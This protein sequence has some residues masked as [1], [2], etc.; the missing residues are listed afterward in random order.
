MIA[1]TLLESTASTND[2]AKQ[3]L[4]DGASTG[5]L[6]VA[7]VQ[8]AGRGRQ[9][10]VWEAA[11]GD[12]LMGSLVVR[13]AVSPRRMSLL[14]LAAGL[15]V[16]E[17]CVQY[18]PHA[19]LKWPN[20]VRVG[21]RKLAGILC[22][23]VVRGDQVLGAVIGVGCNVRAKGLPPALRE[24]AT[25]LE[26]HATSLPNLEDLAQ[27]LFARVLRIADDVLAR[28]LGP[29]VQRLNAVHALG[30]KEVRSATGAHGTVVE[31]DDEG[32]LV[33]RTEQG[34]ERWSSGEVHLVRS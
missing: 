25:S 27:D 23:T 34:L 29:Y 3:A 2:D 28:G 13:R 4:R 16:L 33:V 30:G 1:L 8:T 14:S 6:V 21:E 32:R 26:D 22:E 20:D 10:R 7:R 24:I 31:I 9:G 19:Q 5:T 11:P 15:G 12:C 17:C 18:A